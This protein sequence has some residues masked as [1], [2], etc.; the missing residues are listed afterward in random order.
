[1]ELHQ[2]FQ[3]ITGKHYQF[4]KK[5]VFANLKNKDYKYKLSKLEEYPMQIYYTVYM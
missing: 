4:Q 2:L 3:E 1:M 5:E